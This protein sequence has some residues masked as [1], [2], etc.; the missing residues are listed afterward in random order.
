MWTVKAQ[1]NKPM[2]ESSSN[3]L[4]WSAVM[5]DTEEEAEQWWKTRTA[6]PH[7]GS[8]STMI[9]PQGEVVRVKFG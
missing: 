5:V 9:N 7:R 4:E 2:A 3:E 1:F 8:V 6:R